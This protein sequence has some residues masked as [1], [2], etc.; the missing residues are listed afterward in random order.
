LKK[1]KKI[2]SKGGM[3]EWSNRLDPA[4]T[5]PKTGKIEIEPNRD[6]G[7]VKKMGGGK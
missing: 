7:G 4:R 3:T 5:R 1:K 6:R 2:I